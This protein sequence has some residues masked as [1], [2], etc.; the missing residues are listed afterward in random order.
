MGGLVF[1][2]YV[3]VFSGLLGF[4]EGFLW[5]NFTTNVCMKERTILWIYFRGPLF[6]KNGFHV[7][8][9]AKALERPRS[10]RADYIQFK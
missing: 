1:M 5:S 9:G 2:F 4:Y 7:G 3:C 6:R 8:S 10:G